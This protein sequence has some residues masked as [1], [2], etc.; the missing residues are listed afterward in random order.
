M[1]RD[2]PVLVPLMLLTACQQQAPRQNAQLPSTGLVP[3]TDTDLLVDTGWP[4]A[5]TAE[6]GLPSPV[7]L[8]IA[9]AAPD[10]QAHGQ[11]RFS[12]HVAGTE[13]ELSAAGLRATHTGG[14]GEIRLR[15]SAWGREGTLLPLE[16]TPPLRATCQAQR[17]PRRDGSCA[18]LLELEH[19]G[20]TERWSTTTA[21]VEQAWEL[22]ERPA[23]QGLVELEVEID[24]ATQITLDDD[25]LGLRLMDDT[26]GAWRYAGLRAWDAQGQPLPALLEAADTILRVVLDDAGARY[27]ITVDPTL[28][29]DSKITASDGGYQ[30]SLGF[31]V[32]SAGDVDGDGYD[33][34]II[35]AYQDD[36]G[37]YR[38]GSA[39]LFHGHSGGIDTSRE[40]KLIASDGAD[41]DAYGFAVAGAGDVNGDGYDDVIIGAYAADDRGSSSGSAYVYLGS[42]VGIDAST[43]LELVASDGTADS[44]FSYSLSRAGDVDGDGYDDV[45][46]GSNGHDSAGS[47]AGAAYLFLGGSG[48]IDAASEALIQASDADVSDGF[49]RA[50]SG[51]ADLNGDGY[52][53]LV[54]GAPFEDS[55]GSNAGAIYVY[56]GFSGGFDASSEIKL[57]ASDGN[58]SDQLGYA[59]AM[60]GDTDG[61]GFDDLIAGAPFDDDRGSAS[62][63]AYVYYGA[64]TGIDLAREEKLVPSDGAATDYFGFSVA[65]AG[66]IDGDGLHD[67]LIG[68]YLDDDVAAGSGSAY[69]YMGDSGGIG[70]ELKL[71][72]SDAAS[73]DYL[74]RSAAGA[75]DVNADG[76][77]DIIVGASGEDDLGSNAGAAYLF[78]GTCTATTWYA[79][80]DGD[81]YGDTSSAVSACSAPS[82]YVAADGDCDEADAAINPGATEVCDTLDN[83][84]DYL[85]DESD[86][87]D[88]TLWYAD[89]DG[90]SYGDPGS[91]ITRCNEPVG[92]VADDTDCDDSSSAN[93]P[94][95]TEICDGADNDCDGSIDETG[96]TGTATW[97]ADTDG[98][99]YGDPSASVTTCAA[100]SGYVADD[101]DCD[102]GDA[103]IHPAATE[104]CDGADNDCDGSI[105]EA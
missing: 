26:G 10:F 23:G 87:A 21:G 40:T 89:T 51:A 36:A 59:V 15:T 31:S 12:A 84:C 49:G 61:D 32:S 30:D 17:A 85:W 22:R 97:H 103:A 83:D 81:G 57:T 44:Y 8:H 63:A 58:L 38:A 82:G 43:E 13:L 7:G 74:G 19:P 68:A 64:A 98:D 69:V 77:D 45:I 47:N 3:L 99:G 71:G 28:T 42:S 37:A 34:V 56:L 86:A 35:G 91:A 104:A 41:S 79:D 92:Y 72:A 100:P 93:N 2:L 16:P 62:G 1:P 94:G 9:P 29:E 25:G 14:G 33:D 75:G 55:G 65:G 24:G 18:G 54:V 95:A 96:A 67:L 60:T 80:T 88:A 39:Y 102:D 90:D 76:I 73:N 50:V 27:P 4:L 66:D 52:G 53:D 6:R 70:S 46:L 105:D 101:R 78:L 20:L 48:G 5:T 11:D